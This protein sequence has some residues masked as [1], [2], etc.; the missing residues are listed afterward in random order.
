M[1]NKLI[2]EEQQKPYF[3]ELLKRIELEQTKT[4]VFP[5]KN[6]WFRALELTPYESVKVVII[7][8]DPYHGINQANGLC[9]SV[10]KGIKLP[11]SLLN[12]YKEIELEYGQFMGSCGDLT[13][14][15]K[16]GVLLLNTILTVSENMPLSHKDFGWQTFTDRVIS[17][18]QEK[19]FVVYILL[20]SHAQSYEDKITN[21]QHVILKTSHPSPLSSYRGFMGS[22]IFKNAN[23]ALK[24]NG[25]KEIDWIL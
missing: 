4:R 16:Q 19:A 21:K 5:L 13:P 15:A 20:G 11:K 7:G 23:K 25:I 9:F 1:F 10:N 14:W 17:L 8:Q 24:D 6:N 3:K 12:I 2:A 18:L 22:N